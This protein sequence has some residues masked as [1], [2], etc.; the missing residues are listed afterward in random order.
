MAAAPLTGYRTRRPLVAVLLAVLIA[1]TV[2]ML[3]LGRGGRAAAYLVLVLAATFA[4]LGG[5]IALAWP[6]EAAVGTVQ[7]GAALVGGIDAYRI[8][9]TCRDH[10]QGPWYSRWWGTLAVCLAIVLAVLGVRALVVEPYRIPAGSMLPTLEIGDYIVVDKHRYGLRLPFTGIRI[11]PGEEPRRGDVVVFRYPVDP[12][13]IYIKRL[14]G[15]P[16][17][18]V[19]Y[20][21][22]RLAINGTPVAA[23]PA[24]TY[25][26]RAPGGGQIEGETWR[27]HLDTHVYT[28]MTDAEAPALY[29][30]MVR[31]DSP[32]PDNCQ[33]DARGFVC[34]VPAGHY[35]V[36]GDNRDSSNDSR[37]W[38]F[39]PAANLLGPAFYIWRSGGRPERAGRTIP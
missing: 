36:L 12:G 27:E 21:D 35:L 38:G 7:L 29:P 26:Y 19:E 11:W 14:I 39:V 4:A 18:R 22:K 32:I 13:L 1:P 15:R 28:V 33:Y 34:T 31:A 37:Y 5:A 3:Y 20:R 17:D 16:G 25:V 2:A 23:E 24:G 30:E 6:V 9:R 8:A 10:F